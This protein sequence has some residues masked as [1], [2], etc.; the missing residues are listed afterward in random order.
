M[1][2]LTA[3]LNDLEKSCKCKKEVGTIGV[4]DTR[5]CGVPLIGEEDEP[6][7]TKLAQA[8]NTLQDHGWQFFN[9]FGTLMFFRSER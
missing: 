5:N 6:Y 7:A 3:I 8:L 1:S 2:R 4:I 9:A